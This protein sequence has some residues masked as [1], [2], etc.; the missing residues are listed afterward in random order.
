MAD[1]TPGT[2]AGNGVASTVIETTIRLGL[3]VILAWLAIRIA[4]P[5]IDLLIWAVIIAVATRQ[6]YEWLTRI[7]RGRGWAATVFATVGIVII[8]APAV[9]VSVGLVDSAQRF[10][11]ALKD[12]KV[13]VPAPP[14]RVA[15]LPL[16][17]K[18]VYAAWSLASENLQ[19]ALQRAE[20]ERKAV[21]D[22]LLRTA[23]SAGLGLLQFLA[24][25]VIAALLL[26]NAEAGARLAQDLFLRIAPQTGLRLAALSEQTIRSVATGI[27]GVAII[28]ALLAGL[29]FVVAGI[30]LAGVWTFV[31]LLLAIVQISPALVTL[32]LIIYMFSAS[33]TLSATLFLV[34]IVPVT[35]GDNILKP[36][37]LGRGVDAPMPVIFV[38]AIGGFILDGFIGLFVGAVVLAFA[39]VVFIDWLREEEPGDV[40]SDAARTD[41]GTQ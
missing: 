22:R 1:T 20:P 40:A 18:R 5:F 13:S 19:D 2:P 41:E 34:W 31:V 17:G 38:G 28:Q 21:A 26:V 35:F 6:F 24:S 10:G 29:G 7:L 12:G 8:L 3:I 4:S 9:V 25:I 15:E 16:V 14:E 27:I 39:Y 37:L 32:P 23:G 11:Q 33:D 36:L 30:P